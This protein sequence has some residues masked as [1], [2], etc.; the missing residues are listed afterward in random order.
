MAAEGLVILLGSLL[1]ALFIGSVCLRGACYFY[2][3]MAGGPKSPTSVPEP[4]TGKAMGILAVIMGAN[5]ALSCVIGLAT[6]AGQA[7]GG[8]RGSPGLNLLGAAVSVPLSFLIMAGMLTAM[9]PTT[10]GRSILVT[11]L[12]LLI[13]LIAVAIGVVIAM[14]FGFSIMRYLQ[15][16]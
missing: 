14:A 10:F 9:L 11:L 5:W 3:L 1:L 12:Y 7:A 8:A 13:C 6:S 4:S 16:R 15:G 2:N